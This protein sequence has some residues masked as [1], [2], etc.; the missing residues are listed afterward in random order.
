MKRT[1]A[2]KVADVAQEISPSPKPKRHVRPT[3]PKLYK[4]SLNCIGRELDHLRLRVIGNKLGA[5]D[6]SDL[7]R[8]TRLLGD[9]RKLQEE[10]DAELKRKLEAMPLSELE[11]RAK[12]LLKGKKK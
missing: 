7:A 11:A 8:Y 9:L 1:K 10:V 5:T 4:L 3:I 12:A 2:N 6:A